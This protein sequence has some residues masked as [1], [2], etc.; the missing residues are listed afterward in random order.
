MA[1]CSSR[2]RRENSVAWVGDPL[3]S[4]KK[5]SSLTPLLEFLAASA[6]TSFIRRA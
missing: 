2:D 5:L 4:P 1:Q 6:A 3:D